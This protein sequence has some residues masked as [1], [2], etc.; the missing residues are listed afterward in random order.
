VRVFGRP[1][2]HHEP[3]LHLAARAVVRDPREDLVLRDREAHD[4]DVPPRCAEKP[5]GH[6]AG[7]AVG[8]EKDVVRRRPRRRE[9]GLEVHA[10]VEGTERGEFLRTEPPRRGLRGEERHLVARER[11]VQ[12][13]PGLVPDPRQAVGLP[14]P[15]RGVEDERDAARLRPLGRDVRARQ[16]QDRGRERRG[17]EEEVP[18]ELR[19]AQRA[20]RR[21]PLGDLLPEEEARDGHP[22]RPLP[23]EAEE[24]EQRQRR[25]APEGGG[26]LQAHSSTPASRR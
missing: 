12:E 25:K 22:L 4:P 14:E 2:V 15:R 19:T 10:L 21:V 16:G 9:E 17:L 11:A 23:P 1:A 18:A 20:D 26:R 24:R 3:P 6:P 13:P 5:R 7:R 8:E